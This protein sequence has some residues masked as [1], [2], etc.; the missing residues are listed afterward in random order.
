MSEENKFEQKQAIETEQDATL[1]EAAKQPVTEEEIELP[2]ISEH[3]ENEE[4]CES[5]TAVETPSVQYYWSYRDQ[6]AFDTKS[7]AKARKKGILLYATVMT[8]VFLLCFGILLGTIVWYG[9][10]DDE[11]DAAQPM[12]SAEIYAAVAPATVFIQAHRSS[13]LLSEGTGFFVRSDGYIA[14]NYHV[15]EKATKITVYLFSGKSY[16]ATVVGYD[17]PNDIAVLKINGTD[18]SVP[19]IGNSDQLAVGEPAIAIGHPSGASGAWSITEGIISA[20][21]RK[22]TLTDNTSSATVVPLIQT[23]AAVNHGNSG[24]PLCNC[25]GEIIGIVTLKKTDHEGMGYAI[26]INHAMNIINAIIGG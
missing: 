24:G 9:E 3:R 17:Q 1:A 25:S 22:T 13:T 19:A 20:L 21:N 8:T 5:V 14:T 6:R 10:A 26:Q 4:K 18:F 7:K 2:K 15:I 23:D 16:V 12:T 11:P